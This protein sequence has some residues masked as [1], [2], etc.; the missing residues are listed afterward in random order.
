MGSA[1]HRAAAWFPVLAWLPRYRTKALRGDAIG[2]MTAWAIVVPESVAY[3]QIAGVPPQNAFYAAPIA[4]V[5]YA[6]FGSSRTLVVGATSAAAILS[7]STVSAIAG[8]PKE[9]IE[10][11]ALLCIIAGAILIAAGLL[12]LGFITNFLAETALTGFLF[13][14][15]LV[16]VIRQAGKIV[17]VS[18]GDGNF[19]ERAWHIVDQIGDWSG[20]TIAV[21]LMAIAI[22]LSVERHIPKLPASLLVLTLGIAL[23]ALLSLEDHGVEIVGEIPSAVPSF[24][25]PD[26]SWHQVA[27]L[28]GGA[29]GVALVVFAE[30]YSISNRF[31]RVHGYEV[32]ANQEMLGMGAANAA[33][34]FVRGFPVSGSASRTAAVEGAGGRSQVVSII[35]AALVL[36]TA[37]FLTPLFTELPEPVLGAIVIIAVRGFLRVDTMRL[38]WQRD[39][40]AFAI[41]STATLGVLIFDLL[42]GLVIAVALSLLLFIAYASAPK[43]AVLAQNEF[44]A[45]VDTANHPGLRQIPGLLIVRPDGGLFFGNSN[46]VRH[47]ITELA[48]AETPPVRV[49]CLVLNNS[50]RLGL[51]V[52]DSLRELDEDLGI[53]NVE[54]W[55]ADIPSDAMRQLDQDPLAAKLGAER[56][57]PNATVAVERFS[58]TS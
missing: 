3:A 10:L 19:F 38:Y 5:A 34:G 58:A 12:R 40:R 30:S 37:A 6:I 55:L 31:A 53:R 42:P 52:L 14:M 36:V 8:T 2:A 26:V 54:L 28:T 20:V 16:I 22:L 1:E 47:A 23:S 32:D 50:Y 45:F 18:S 49:V 15:A 35:A 27:Q 57:F 24:H 46:R 56:V 4:L 33:V 11:S 21:G 17:G 39:R 7:A 44:G 48:A 43:L 13:G 41:A 51:S 29:F 25:V 9:S